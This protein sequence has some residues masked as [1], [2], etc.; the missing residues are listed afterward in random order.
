M[1]VSGIRSCDV[2]V[3]VAANLEVRLQDFTVRG[4]ERLGVLIQLPPRKLVALTRARLAIA[5][6]A[7]AAELATAITFYQLSTT[8]R[9][10]QRITKSVA[11]DILDLTRSPVVAQSRARKAGTAP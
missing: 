1:Y 6:A 2:A 11:K 8:A 4:I 5:E 9:R 7:F 3:A 10:T